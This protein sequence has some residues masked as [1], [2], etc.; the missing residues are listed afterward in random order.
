MGET[1]VFAD[2]DS[3]N[4]NL[5]LAQDVT[6]T[7]AGTI[8]S[9]SFY[10]RTAA[11]TMRLG[12]YDAAGN[13]IVQTGSFTPVA[14]WN[15]QPVGQVLLAPGGYWLAYTPN[16]PNLSFPVSRLSGMHCKYVGRSFQAMPAIFPAGA[17]NDQC[18]WSFY[19]TLSVP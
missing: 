7:R 6:L 1:T 16:S 8:Q 5:L 15:T 14:G 18:H 10:A 4:A 11:G 2:T 9:L 12:L 13:I 19:A 17:T 3:G